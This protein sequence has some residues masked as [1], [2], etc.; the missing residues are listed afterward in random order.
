MLVDYVK[1]ALKFRKEAD[2]ETIWDSFP[3]AIKES[4]RHLKT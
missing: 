4:Y 3:D 1:E 2:V